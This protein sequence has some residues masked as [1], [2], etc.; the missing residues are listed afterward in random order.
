[1]KKL[2]IVTLITVLI[3]SITLLTIF[4]IQ[5]QKAQLDADSTEIINS[6]ILGQ[7]RKLLVHLP[8]DYFKSKNKKY[9]VLYALDATS[10]DQDILTASTVLN[11]AGQI[12]ELII[13]G[14]VNENR[15]NDLTPHYMPKGEESSNL[16]NGVDFMSFLE[17]EAIPLIDKNYRTTNYRMIS[18]NSRA[19]LFTFYCMLENPALFNAYF[20]YSPAFW[21][22]NNVIARKLEKFLKEDTT[23]SFLYLSIGQNENEKMKKGFDK[24]IEILKLSDSTKSHIYHEY[25]QNA[26]H[27]TN[28]F[29]SIPRALTIWNEKR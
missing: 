3:T 28:A 13:I 18:G 19:G 11:L 9:P 20:C 12:P 10:H 17:N 27:G 1:M 23:N 22:D 14:V 21:R 16:G 25:T 24:V 26:N 5:A 4:E 29:Y 7:K 6:K 2:I 15:K 8:R